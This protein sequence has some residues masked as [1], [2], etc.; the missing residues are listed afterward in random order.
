MGFLEFDVQQDVHGKYIGAFQA[1]NF[2][3]P[4]KQKQQPISGIKFVASPISWIT[5][6]YFFPACSVGVRI[7]FF[8]RN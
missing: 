8:F 2:L 3:G 6:D 1:L 7:P 4:D 5:S